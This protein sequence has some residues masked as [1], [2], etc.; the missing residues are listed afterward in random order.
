MKKLFSLLLLV[1]ISVTMF[2]T[3]LS[4]G[5]GFVMNQDRQTDEVDL[6]FFGRLQTG[7]SIFNGPIVGFIAD[8][9]I[10]GLTLKGF[11][12]YSLD[13]A[14]TLF[15]LF[16]EVGLDDFSASLPPIFFK[17]T[18]MTEARSVLNMRGVDQ[19]PLVAHL[20]AGYE[21]SDF[22]VEAGSSIINVGFKL[23][24][25]LARHTTVFPHFHLA[26]RYN[27]SF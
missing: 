5:I 4:V 2:S 15:G 8:V 17:V 3:Q 16:G 10:F 24:D 1:F 21:V 18:T 6:Q 23:G 9:P 20:E 11:E 13:P 26:A 25:K 7:W 22:S 14:E 12:F 19:L 27:F